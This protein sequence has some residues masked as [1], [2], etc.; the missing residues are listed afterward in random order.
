[1]SIWK[2]IPHLIACSYDNKHVWSR[3]ESDSRLCA[4]AAAR[5]ARAVVPAYVSDFGG[6][7][8]SDAVI[9]GAH[10]PTFATAPTSHQLAQHCETHYK[11]ETAWR[12]RTD[13]NIWLTLPHTFW[14]FIS[15]FEGSY[16]HTNLPSFTWTNNN[17]GV[18]CLSMSCLSYR[19]PQ[20]SDVH[21]CSASIFY[22]LYSTHP[23]VA[24]PWHSSQGWV[25]FVTYFRCDVSRTHALWRTQEETFILVAYWL[26]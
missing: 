12:D 17:T 11:T 18:R 2:L 14:A 19:W 25:L 10:H 3:A 15:K 8:R 26:S 21:P 7:S 24:P 13:S 9:V 4:V 16:H 1:M 20:V 6:E 22:F 5:P 23:R